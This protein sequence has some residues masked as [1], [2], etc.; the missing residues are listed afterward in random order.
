MRT[1][2]YMEYR[3]RRHDGMYRW[4]SDNG[5]PRFTA[6]GIFEGFIGACSDIHDTRT[7]AEKIEK[8]ELL[9][10]TCLLYT[11]RCV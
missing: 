7:A 3:L 11:S 9:F 8:S 6:D 1:P 5:A 10:K 2:F 4:L